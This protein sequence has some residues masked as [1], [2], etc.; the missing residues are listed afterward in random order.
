MSRLTFRAIVAAVLLSGVALASTTDPNNPED[1]SACATA[2]F[3]PEVHT[4]YGDRK[5]VLAKLSNF[6]TNISDLRMYMLAIDSAGQSSFRIF[7]RDPEDAT[8]MD[9]YAWEG[10]STDELKQ[11][12]AAAS[13]RNRGFACIGAQSKALVQKALNPE[14]EG[15]I[16]APS[17][18]MKA[19]S[20]VIEKYDSKYIRVTIYLMC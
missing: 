1:P 2:S 13:L 12:I 16:Q 20:S 3:K 15:Q 18:A 9:V 19:F 5:T 4:F 8:K 17:T 11:Q 6:Q 7:E 10:S 14:K